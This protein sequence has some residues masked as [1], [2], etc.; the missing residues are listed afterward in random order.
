[1]SPQYIYFYFKGNI[2]SAH[3]HSVEAAYS[4]LNFQREVQAFLSN[5]T[6]TLIDSKGRLG[7]TPASAGSRETG[8]ECGSVNSAKENSFLWA[9]EETLII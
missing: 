6:L 3:A 1:M 9:W 4:A 5:T 2:T 8:N 7:Q